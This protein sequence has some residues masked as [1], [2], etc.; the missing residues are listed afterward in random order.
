MYFYWQS[1]VWL[2]TL[3]WQFA[4]WWGFRPLK[5]KPRFLLLEKTEIS[6]AGLFFSE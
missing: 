5:P 6:H 3:Q 4:K 1:F 2:L